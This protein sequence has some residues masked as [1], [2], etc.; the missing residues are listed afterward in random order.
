M[1]RPPSADFYI[2]AGGNKMSEQV[3]ALIASISALA[4]TAQ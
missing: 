3:L 2:A 1:I 4:G